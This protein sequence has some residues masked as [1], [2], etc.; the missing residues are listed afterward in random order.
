MRVNTQVLA[1]I[2]VVIALSA[3]GGGGSGGT[4]AATPVAT[5]TISGSA[6]KGPVSGA[7]VTVKKASDGSILKTTT[8]GAGGVY[9]LSVDYTGD[10]VV[11]VTGGTYTDEATNESTQLAAPLKSVLAANGGT[12]SGIV[13]PL[14]TMAYTNAFPTGSAI[15]S[16]TFKTYATNLANQFKLSADELAS[17]P[18]VTG[19]TN[20]YGKVLAGL[21]KYMQFENKTLAALVNSSFSAAE[22]TTFS[23]T[24]SNAYKAANPGTNISYTFNGDTLSI[25]GTGSGGG[26]GTCGIGVSGTVTVNGTPVPINQNYC[27]SGIAAGSCTQGNSSISQAINQQGVTGTANLAYTYATTCAANALAINLL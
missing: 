4:T 21:S 12:V 25:S 14:T 16:S 19:N 11:E 1:S 27:L 26:S 10:V 6:V 17:T 5:T 7:T 13:T 3:C 8:T 15:S 22:W 23:G 20:A 18:V 9:S 24:F 2:S